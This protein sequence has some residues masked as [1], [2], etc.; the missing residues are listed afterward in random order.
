V[1]FS[2][3]ASRLVTTWGGFSPRWYA[4]LLHDRTLIT[5]AL[6]SLR[7]AAVSATLAVIVGALAGYALARFGRFAGRGAFTAALTA[8]LVLPEVITGLSLLLLF[9]AL[10]QATGRPAGRGASTVTLAHASVSVAYVAVVV[11]A[12]LAGTPRDLEEAA[13]DLYAPPWRAFAAVTLPLMAPALIAGWLLAFTLSLDD[14][15]VA[16]FTSGPG[17]STLPMVVFSSIKLGPTPELYALAT[18]IVAVVAA[19]L[20]AVWRVQR[21]AEAA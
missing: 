2:F 9:V 1:A 21:R 18:V 12:R 20:L 8:P 6:L 13:M 19:I 10:Q 4:T 15:V 3:N 16:S 17:A 7:I 14:V 5:A 11:R